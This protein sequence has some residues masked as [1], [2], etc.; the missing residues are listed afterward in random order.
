MKTITIKKIAIV[1][2][3]M[4]FVALANLGRAQT[5]IYTDNFDIPG[6]TSLDG[7]DQ[8]GRHT[9]LF[10]TNVLG[11]CGGIQFTITSS[12]L[13]V[14]QTGG[15]SDGRMRFAAS[16]NVSGTWDWASGS[17]GLVITTAG[18]AD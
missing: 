2:L 12:N 7:S 9:G 4:A 5:V 8:T 1:V 18:G 11:R 15:G 6:I 3:G 16:T 14:F 17:A 10:A 13:N